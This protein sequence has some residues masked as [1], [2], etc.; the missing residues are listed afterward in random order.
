MSLTQDATWGLVVEEF[1]QG[2]SALLLNL[3]GPPQAVAVSNLRIKP[4]CTACVCVADQC[5]GIVG[6]DSTQ[7]NAGLAIVPLVTG[8]PDVLY[9]SVIGADGVTAD[10]HLRKIRSLAV[11]PPLSGS[12]TTSTL[13]A[14]HDGYFTETD[15]WSL[16][17]SGTIEYLGTC[18]Q[19]LESAITCLAF[20]PSGQW[21]VRGTEYGEVVLTDI[22][23]NRDYALLN[24]SD[25]TRVI[26]LQF[27]G[28][29]LFAA[30]SHGVTVMRWNFGEC[31][32]VINACEQTNSIPKVP[33]L[34]NYE[35]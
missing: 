2:D 1:V 26:Q 33:S 24:D 28:N 7:S 29:R 5:F 11:A 21:L 35:G 31:I 10:D 17:P 14:G 9:P 16:K 25:L 12:D 34:V 19:P 18:G 3:T 30:F 32:M 13:A 4:L 20:D 27:V 15:L 8:I 6:G 22:Q 23:R